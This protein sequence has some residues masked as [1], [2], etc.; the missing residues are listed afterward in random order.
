MGKYDVYRQRKPQRWNVVNR[1]QAGS[2]LAGAG[3]QE[4]LEQ[5]HTAR[6][7]SRRGGEG[8]TGRPGD[9]G[10]MEED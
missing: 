10:G 7:S 1:Y 2:S 4:D 3:L 8:D 6:R 5:T 9:G